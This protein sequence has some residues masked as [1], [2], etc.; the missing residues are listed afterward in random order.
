MTS[1]ITPLAD[2]GR[3][4]A[5]G[6]YDAHHAAACRALTTRLPSTRRPSA[7]V[8]TTP[9]SPNRTY[10]DITITHTRSGTGAATFAEDAHYRH[11]R[12]REAKP[13]AQ[14]AAVFGAGLA[15]IAAIVAAVGFFFGSDWAPLP[16]GFFAVSAVAGHYFVEDLWDRLWEHFD[17]QADAADD[18][19]PERVTLDD[20]TGPARTLTEH[21]LAALAALDDS[22]AW[23]SDWASALATQIDLA[24]EAVDLVRTAHLI[25]QLDHALTGPGAPSG[26]RW[27]AL[28]RDRSAAVDALRR[29]V[30]DLVTLRLGVDELDELLAAADAHDRVDALAAAVRGSIDDHKRHG[31]RAAELAAAT[32][33]ARDVLTCT[34]RRSERTHS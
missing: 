20:L 4:A 27:I 33:A 17:D 28:D 3:A 5:G 16:I 18:P 2:L 26:G 32:G 25:S 21:G 24:D 22:P 7:S 1:P 30:T 9:V 15:P 6:S 19:L 23:H 12:W 14:A 10:P 8:F 34:P 31:D 11:P 13:T 29:R